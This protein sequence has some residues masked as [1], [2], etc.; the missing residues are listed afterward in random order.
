MSV[1][2]YSNRLTPERLVNETRQYH[3]V[4]PSLTRA[5]GVEQAGDNHRQGL[6]IMV[7]ESQELIDRFGAGI[8]PAAFSGRSVNY[9]IIFGE[10]VF[11]TFP[12]DFGG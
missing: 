12:V 1:P 3:P 5:R 6:G 2:E 7:R 8:T 9:I 4:A 11:C 10:R